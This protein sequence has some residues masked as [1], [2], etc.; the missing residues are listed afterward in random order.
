V[1]RRA[2]VLGWPIGHSR[3]PAMINAAFAA[4][5][6]D[7][8]MEPIGVPPERLAA[9]VRELADAR[10][11][12]AS[13]TIPHKEPV[14]ALCDELAPAAQ[15]AGAVNCLAFPDDGAGRVIGH[16]TDGG[17]FIDSVRELGLDLDDAL[18][19]LLGAGGA[20]RGLHA[21]LVEVNARVGVFA[22]R[23]E[24]VA[25]THAVAWSRR[26]ELEEMFAGAALVVDCTSTAL[27]PA[28]EG[29]VVDSL[30]LDACDRDAVVASL[31]YHRRPLLLERA[32]ARGLRTLDGRGMLVHQGA[33]AFTLWTGRAA[34]VEVM[35]KALDASIADH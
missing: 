27:D 26:D 3:S 30:P 1:T 19:V 18:V 11:L 8:V 28:A 12:G 29:Q 7:A 13:V 33:R 15:A 9:V 22:R 21:A 20:A 32:A 25:W 35:R 24:A 14:A 6:I 16:N 4:T 23:P 5:G 10:A 17:G 31:V 34:P 2:A